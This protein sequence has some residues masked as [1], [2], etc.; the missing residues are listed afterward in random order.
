MEAIL[1]PCAAVADIPSVLDPGEEL[2]AADSFGVVLRVAVGPGALGEGWVRGM[3]GVKGDENVAVGGARDVL[4][5]VHVV[6]KA[7]RGAMV[8]G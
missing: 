3:Q 8:R 4:Q 2:L 7:D 5:N 1:G 6:G